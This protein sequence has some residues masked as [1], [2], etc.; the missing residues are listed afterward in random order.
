MNIPNNKKNE[1][2]LQENTQAYY[3]SK[4][5]NR[6]SL[7]GPIC[8]LLFITLHKQVYIIQQIPILV[9]F[10]HGRRLKVI[11]S[12]I[13]R[14]SVSTPITSYTGIVTF[15]LASPNVY[16]NYIILLTSPLI[17]SVRCQNQ[18]RYRVTSTLK[19]QH[20]PSANS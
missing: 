13:K 12:K 18:E 1:F 11:H 16:N 17:S 20:H 8:N 9:L 5:S 2:R 6:S 14:Q 4:I 15:Y 7:A 19:Y 3:Y 10:P